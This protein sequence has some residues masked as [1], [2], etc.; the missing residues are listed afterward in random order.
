MLIFTLLITFRYL[1]LFKTLN[2][3]R[4]SFDKIVINIVIVYLFF[5]YMFIY[6]IKSFK[7]LVKYL[8]VSENLQF[9]SSKKM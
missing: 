6:N 9:S 7:V 2:F 1:N 4:G 3:K 8:R 5:I